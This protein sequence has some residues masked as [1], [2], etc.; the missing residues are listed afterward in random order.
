MACEAKGKG[1]IITLHLFKVS[2]DFTALSQ[3]LW[4]TLDQQ[5][6]KSAH[7]TLSRSS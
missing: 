7:A 3:Q 1:R 6:V 2:T 4:A 5:R